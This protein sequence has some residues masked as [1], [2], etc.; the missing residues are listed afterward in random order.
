MKTIALNRTK[1]A[2]GQ[3]A[4]IPAHSTVAERRALGENRVTLDDKPA[5]ITGFLMDFPHIQSDD[6]SVEF[7]WETV[8]NVVA[9]GGNF[10]SS[11]DKARAARKPK[12][13]RENRIAQIRDS[14]ESADNATLAKIA[15]LLKLA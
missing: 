1:P 10:F 11:P 15:E 8:A 4:A 2:E 5:R 14:L 3:P 6:Q 9:Q 13:A 12:S 7:A